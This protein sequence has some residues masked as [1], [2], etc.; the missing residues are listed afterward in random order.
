M[1]VMWCFMY[2]EEKTGENYKEA[3][4]LWREKERERGG[5]ERGG[6]RER[7]PMTRIYIGVNLLL[8]QNYISKSRI[9]GI[10]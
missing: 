7:N 5:R 8:N 1:K 6:G 2:S 9:A 3:C 4:E 10:D